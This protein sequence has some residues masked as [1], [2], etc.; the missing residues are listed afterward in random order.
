MKSN[1]FWYEHVRLAD[2]QGVGQDEPK[3]RS[4]LREPVAVQNF[5]TR[6][7]PRAFMRDAEMPELTTGSEEASP[8]R[9]AKM[10]IP[11]NNESEA[12]TGSEVL[13]TV[14]RRRVEIP[15]RVHPST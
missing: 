7:A 3:Q 4:P 15:G 2:L 13:P 5:V 8:V 12:A 14:V 11:T 6:V 1:R 9:K 10:G